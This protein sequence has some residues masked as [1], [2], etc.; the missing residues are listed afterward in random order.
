MLDRWF[1]AHPRSLGESYFKHQ[2]RALSF[3]VHLL[4][5]GVACFIHAL[6]PALFQRTASRTVALLY[7]RMTAKAAAQST[8]I[9]TGLMH[10]VEYHI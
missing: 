5:A 6:V 8:Q 10:S 2:Q 3:A 1:L 7:S 4:G 9:G